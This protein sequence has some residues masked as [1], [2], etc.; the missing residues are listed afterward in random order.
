MTNLLKSDSLKNVADV[1]AQ[2]LLL[3]SP[4]LSLCLLLSHLFPSRP[5]VLAKVK[6]QH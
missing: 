1:L 4:L 5:A 6:G 3:S 2:G